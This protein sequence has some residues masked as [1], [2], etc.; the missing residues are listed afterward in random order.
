M[1]GSGLVCAEY[2]AGRIY[3]SIAARRLAS[4]VGNVCDGGPMVEPGFPHT[5]A[6]PA[7]LLAPSR[8]GPGPLGH[9]VFVGSGGF[10]RCVEGGKPLPAR[11]GALTWLSPMA[12]GR[13]IYWRVGGV[14]HGAR[15]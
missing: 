2:D 9:T 3:T 6:G 15:R 4:G 12:L 7:W 8:V 1:G 14:I 5:E 10:A 13:G 11:V